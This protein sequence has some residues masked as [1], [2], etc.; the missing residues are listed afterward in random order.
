[1]EKH[2]YAIHSHP[3]KENLLWDQLLARNVDVFY[4]RI[5]VKPV[6]PRSRKILPYFPG[7]LFVCTDLE[8]VGVSLFQWMPYATG[9]VRFGGDPAIVPESLILGIRQKVGEIAQA[10]GEVNHGLKP[11]DRI[12]VRDGL[13]AGYEGIFDVRLSGKERVR[14]LL[15]MLN[16]RKVP[17]EIGIEAIQKKK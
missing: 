15:E 13:F 16:S 1:M 14:V 17:L 2:W 3:N 4:P 5:P 6:N 9:L 8:Q 10:G 11:G 7:Y 12:V